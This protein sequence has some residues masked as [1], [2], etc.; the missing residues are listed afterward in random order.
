MRMLQK[1]GWSSEPDVKYWKEKGWS[2][3]ERP[4]K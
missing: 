2:D 1:K 4:W 3:S